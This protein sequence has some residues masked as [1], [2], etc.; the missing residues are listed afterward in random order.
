MCIHFFG[1]FAFLFVGVS[2]AGARVFMSKAMLNQPSASKKYW[3]MPTPRIHIYNVATTYYYRKQ[4]QAAYHI[5]I[6]L[7]I[8]QKE[9]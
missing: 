9:L 7:G 2:V 4:I 6:Y 5:W 3:Q 8:S 1:A